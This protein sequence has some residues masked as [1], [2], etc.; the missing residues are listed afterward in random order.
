MVKISA[1][2]ISFNEEKYIGQCISS[3]EGIADEIIVVDSFSTDRTSDICREL[4]VKFTTRAFNG[5]RDQKNY[6][7]SLATNNLIFSIDAD[8]A[9]SQQ[10]KESLLE[11]KRGS[12]G[13]DYCT[14]NRLNRCSGKWIR[15]SG[16]YPDRKIRL[17]NR[18]K[19]SWGGL[20]VHET[21]K[22]DDGSRKRHLKGDL[23]HYV[24]DTFE[25]FA[26]KSERYA[27]FCGAEYHARGRRAGFFTPALHMIWR[28]LFN[29]TVRGGFL[30]G[31]HGFM[32]CRLNAR[33]VYLKYKTLRDL[34]KGTR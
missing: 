20:N 25:E 24:Y 11:F 19:G 34:N 30:D 12:T 16:L 17:Y 32:I 14:V 3:L 5:Y 29:Y 22:M 26:E 9:V 8:E 27:R 33:Y 18:D 28:F 21:I 4:G 13:I 6:A 23:L 1:V 2:I 15:H 10:L 7:A 31:Y